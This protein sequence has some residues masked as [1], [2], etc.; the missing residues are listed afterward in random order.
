MID[1]ATVE[2]G[3]VAIY[4][5]AAVV[6]FG[7][8]RRQR[9]ELRTYCY[10]LVA[11]VGVSAVGSALTTAGIG[12]LPI[13]SGLDLPGF[14]DD[15]FAYAVLFGLATYIGGA[16]RRMIALVAGLSVG[17]RVAFEFP[18]VLGGSGIAL[19]M[20]VVAIITYVARVYLMFGPVARTARTLPADRRLL[21]AK[22]RN[23]LL[24]LL[25]MLIT[26]ALLAV[27]G[28][29]DAY[30]SLVALAYV[31][32]WLRI[33]FAGFLVSRIDALEGAT[34]GDAVGS[35][36]DSAGPATSPDVPGA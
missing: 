28:Y 16:S 30:V 36:D 20:I 4:A 21:Y 8:A 24:F 29:F 12:T 10:L 34:T 18:T 15:V 31:D 7:L 19:G 32:F 5:I 3:T 9:E 27:F 2:W 23:V 22:A 11:V 6:I 13:G 25:G 17:S 35:T 26:G 1:P 14:V 33:G